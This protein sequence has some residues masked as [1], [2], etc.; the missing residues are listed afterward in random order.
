MRRLFQQTL[1][2]RKYKRDKSTSQP[3]KWS[4]LKEVFSHKK[5]WGIYLGQFSL[6]GTMWF[7]LTWFPT[8]LVKYRDM[9][10]IKSGFLASVPFLFAFAGVLLSGFLSDYMIKKGLSTGMA[11]KVFCSAHLLSGPI[12]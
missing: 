11:R 9:D 7:F 10:F 8:Y 6:G 1:I 3:F 5:L 4:D 2:N 12:M